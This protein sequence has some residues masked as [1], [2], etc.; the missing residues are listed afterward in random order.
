MNLISFR[1]FVQ[2]I[3][4]EI[5]VVADK[6]R[7]DAEAAR[8]ESE[9]KFAAMVTINIS[10]CYPTKKYCFFSAGNVLTNFTLSL[11]FLWCKF[12]TH[13]CLVCDT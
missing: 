13:F 7:A 4:R 1:L 11:H 10:K 9:W 12:N 8:I 5:S 6:I 2:C 3:R